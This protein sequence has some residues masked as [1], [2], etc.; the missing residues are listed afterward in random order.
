MIES[1]VHRYPGF[2]GVNA[3]RHDAAMI[4]VVSTTTFFAGFESTLVDAAT[5]ATIAARQK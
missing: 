2:A 5:I 4:A 3:I 1:S